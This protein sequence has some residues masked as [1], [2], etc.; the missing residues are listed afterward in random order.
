MVI[1]VSHTYGQNV[2]Q[3]GTTIAAPRQRVWDALVAA[4]SLARFTPAIEVRADWR[5]GGA[6]SWK[7]PLEGRTY[8]VEG[9]VVRVEAPHLLEYEYG[10]PIIHARHRVTIELTE[11]GAGTRV[12][13]AEDG[14]RKEV[15]LLHGVGAWRLVLANLKYQLESEAGRAR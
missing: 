10:N 4:D 6:L 8:A 3:A 9:R 5:P 11:D 13:V 15:D 12:A 14:H 2:A 1:A 7:A